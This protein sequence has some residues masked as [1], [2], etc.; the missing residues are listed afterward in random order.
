[1]LS[2]CCTFS[3]LTMVALISPQWWLGLLVC[4][5]LLLGYALDSADGQL[6]RLLGAGSKR[7][8]WLDH[9]VDATKVSVLHGTVLISFYRF[10]DRRTSSSWWP[11][12]I[13]PS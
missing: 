2:A 10:T 3:A 9:T 12:G 11:W 4:G 6:A 1:M 7:G 13:R 8:E 5:L